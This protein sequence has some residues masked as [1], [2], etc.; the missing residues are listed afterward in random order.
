MSETRTDTLPEHPRPA[1]AGGAPQAAEAGPAGA[2]RHRG[3]AAAEEQTA[4]APEAHGRHR[5]R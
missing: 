1:S 3:G 5:R 4:S 2:G